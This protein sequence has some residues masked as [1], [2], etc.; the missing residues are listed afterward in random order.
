M[1]KVW[2]NKKKKYL[3]RRKNKTEHKRERTAVQHLR[4]VPIMSI[5]E[6]SGGVQ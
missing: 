4:T 2:W 5:L 6:N 1:L 3:G